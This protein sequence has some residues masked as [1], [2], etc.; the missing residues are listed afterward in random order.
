MSATVSDYLLYRLS[1][2]GIRRIYGYPGDGINGILGAL[3]RNSEFQFIQTRH[4]EMAAFMACAHA[5]F[6][7]EPGVCL[8]T[9]GPGAIHLLNGLY[10]A[11]LDHQPVVAIVGQQKSMGLGGHYQ[12]EV[13]LPVLFKDVASEYITMVTHPSAVRH[14][15][16]RA[17]RIARAERT[18]TCVIIPNDIQEEPYQPP[19]RVHGSIHSSVGYSEP[20]VVPQEKD[21]KR[22]AE[23]LNAGKKVAMLV[24]AG[25]LRAADELIE[26]ADLL[27]AG[28]AKALLGKAVLPD[29]LPFVTGA[30]GLL[31]TR[32]SWDMMMECDTLLM[33]GTSFPYSEFLPPEGQARGVQIDLDGRMLAIRYPMEVPLTGD[34][35]ETLRALIPLLKRKED[36]NWRDGLEKSIRQWWKASEGMAMKDANPINPQRVFWELSPKLPE[37]VILSSDSGSAANW[38]ARDLKIRQGMMAS[39]SGNLAT[40]GC[41]VPYAIGAKFA[42]P[43]RP[44]IALVGDGAMQMNGNAELITV[45]KYWKEWKDPRF[46]V[47][48]LNNR[49]LNQVTWEQR[50]LAG[51][52]KLPATQNLPDFPYARYAE[53]IGLRGIRV[54]KPE[55]IARAWDQAL[56]SDRPVVLEA[57]TDPDVP[58]LPPHIT[59]EQAKHFAQSMMKGDVNT[60]GILKQSIKGLVEQFKPHKKD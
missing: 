31:G 26:V 36:R 56:S 58:P 1:Q 17:L 3:G 32:P 39:L 46:I 41:G 10:D 27:G 37:G 9:S 2:W 57:Y 8:A 35:K 25:A 6:T 55:Q 5:K 19:P 7:G 59:L 30:I 28:V 49:D 47:L 18:V 33:V 29:S 11:K 42:Y 51:D 38:F 24:G 16:D 12:Q 20:R 48:V 54:D 44:V 15:V 14:A 22:A 34:S 60:G 45:A 21:L 43:D 52:P 40:M 13:D 4:E 23:V 53:S 50:V